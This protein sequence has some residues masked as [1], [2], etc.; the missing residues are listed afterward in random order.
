MLAHAKM[1]MP[2]L[3]TRARVIT[4]AFV[5][6]NSLRSFDMCVLCHPGLG[7][8]CV[9]SA[10]GYRHNASEHFASVNSL[11]H[12]VTSNTANILVMREM[13]R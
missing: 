11:K 7:C 10:I 13:M 12:Y 9:A 6:V 3:L 4:Q 8:M 2:I 5:V 1:F